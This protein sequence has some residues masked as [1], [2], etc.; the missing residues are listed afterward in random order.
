M[1]SVG[2][3]TDLIDIKKAGTF[4][5]VHGIR[6]MSIERGV[7]V[8]PT[9][10]RIEALVAGGV[11]SGELGRELVSA[12]YFFMDIRLRSQLRAVKTGQR[13]M[14]SIV[15]L[16]ELSTFDRDVLRDALRVVKQFREVVRHRYN[17][18]LF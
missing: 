2:V 15:R 1:A 8:T 12:L 11:L 16:S 5:I 4:P 7:M 17:L 3:G 6:T 18:G 9:A 13:E 14:E 10:K